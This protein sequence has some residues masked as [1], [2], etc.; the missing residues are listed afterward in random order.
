[1]VINFPIG[2]FGHRRGRRKINILTIK[3]PC[4]LSNL[5]DYTE[6]F[7]PIIGWSIITEEIEERYM[8]ELAIVMPLLNGTLSNFETTEETIIEMFIEFNYGFY[9]AQGKLGFVHKDISDENIGYKKTSY[10]RI[11]LINNRSYKI[12][13]PYRFMLFDFETSYLDGDNEHQILDL[14][15]IMFVFQYFL[16]NKEYNYPGMDRAEKR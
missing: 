2:S 15:E 16:E 6:I 7:V 12:S 5:I 14:K 8:E 10:N 4:Q 1:M 9:L 11:Y 3:V 13:S